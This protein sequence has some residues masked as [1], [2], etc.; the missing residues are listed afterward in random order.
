MI[1]EGGLTFD[2]EQPS[3]FLKI[4]NHVAAHRFGKA[5]LD[6]LDIYES[7]PTAFR[8]LSATGAPDRVL[9]GYLRLMRQHDVGDHAFR[10]SEGDHRD[11]LWTVMFD[12]PALTASAEF[13]VVKVRSTHQLQLAAADMHAGLWTAWVS[14]LTY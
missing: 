11:R 14:R 4:P 1:Y 3:K 10:K 2:S 6:R 8:T 13:K 9:S 7:M 5:V 12:N